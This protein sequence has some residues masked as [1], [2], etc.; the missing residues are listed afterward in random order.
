MSGVDIE[1][2]VEDGE[3]NAQDHE[4]NQSESGDP[5]LQASTASGRRSQIQGSKHYT[6]SMH[7]TKDRY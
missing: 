1:F 4:G 7:H 6:S 5:R 2:S 3:N